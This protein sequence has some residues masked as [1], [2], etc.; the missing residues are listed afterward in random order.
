[1]SPLSHY[2]RAVGS[3]V[4]MPSA[5]RDELY[6]STGAT[7]MILLIAGYLPTSAAGLPVGA[8][9]RD[10]AASNVIKVVPPA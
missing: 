10:A 9:W 2:S 7:T 1:M 5:D 3:V 8:L 4:R 6:D